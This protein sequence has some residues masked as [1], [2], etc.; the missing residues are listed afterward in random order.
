M[1]AELALSQVFVSPASLP[2]PQKPTLA[3]GQGV[4]TGGDRLGSPMRE[5]LQERRDR[6]L[7]VR[8]QRFQSLGHIAGF[9]A[10]GGDRFFQRRSTAVVE[11]AVPSRRLPKAGR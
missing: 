6:L 4:R 11:V 8:R 7:V 9:T 5:R 1:N 2:D 10:M 3:C